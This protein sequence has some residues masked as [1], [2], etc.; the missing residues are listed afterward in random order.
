VA[1]TGHRR[2]KVRV[3]RM[4]ASLAPWDEKTV[5]EFT[6]SRMRILHQRS[7]KSEIRGEG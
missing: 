6:P 7:S 2:G 1:L 3:R 4:G 5:W